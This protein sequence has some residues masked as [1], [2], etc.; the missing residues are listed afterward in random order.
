MKNGLKITRRLV[1]LCT[2]SVD[3]L[4]Q[5]SHV[6]ILGWISHCS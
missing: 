2:A 1:K 4:K 3:A 6:P 5:V